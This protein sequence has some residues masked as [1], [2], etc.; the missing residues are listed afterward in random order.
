MDNITIPGI[1]SSL[2]WHNQ[3]ANWSIT[4]TGDLVASAGA[5]TDWF[6]NPSGGFEAH[7]SA[8]LLFQPDPVCLL[9]AHMTVDFVGLFDAGVLVAYQDERL[10]AKL[11]L[12][13]SPLGKLMIVS[14]VTRG[15]SDDS[16]GYLVDGKSA[17]LRL[18]RLGKAF[19]FHASAD[20]KA[21][22]LIRH[23]SIGDT[24]DLKLGFM[25][26]A[27]TGPGCTVT[28]SQI[29]YQPV[30]LEDIRSGK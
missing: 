13:L 23:F 10:W 2:T 19:A 26:Q 22:N 12:E 5:K 18:S 29:R 4:T 7:S 21:W 25:A 24:P 8:A 17:H 1:P 6:I 11:C 14:V 9:S 20:G 30:L 15:V 3:P 28:F 16:N 27:P